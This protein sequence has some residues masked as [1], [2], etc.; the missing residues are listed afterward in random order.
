MQRLVRDILGRLRPTELIELGLT[1]AV[2]ELVAF[3]SGRAA[4]AS[5]FAVDA[6]RRRGRS[7][8]TMRE[9]L[10][11]VIQEGLNNAVRHGRPTRI[12]IAVSRGDRR[13]DP[14]ARDRDDGA[15]SGKPDGAGFGLSG[16]RERVEAAGGV[17]TISRGRDGGGW[18][19]AGAGWPASA[20]GEARRGER[21]MNI[22]LVD[23]HAL[24]RAGL[25]RLL[26]TA[27]RRRDPGGGRRP[28]RPGAGRARLKPDLIILDLNLPGLG[29]LEL[30]RRMIQAG[31]P[32]R[33]WC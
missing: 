21:R 16:M 8:P 24:V 3:W 9:T 17:L 22:L 20:D 19:V 11:R 7:S 10:Y 5:R 15:P 27:V 6:A 32:G 18:T 29:G 30:L 1:A 14:G 23:D 4:R 28:R 13:R 12:E 2:D 33:S 31:R 25:K 26:A